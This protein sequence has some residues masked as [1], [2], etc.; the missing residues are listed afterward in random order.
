MN[1]LT[2]CGMGSGSSLILKMNVDEILEAEGR[3]AEVEACDIGSVGAHSADLIL[4]TRDFKDPLEEYSVDKIFLGNVVDKVAIK[5]ELD[6]YFEGK[7][8]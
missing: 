8:N 2:V 6:K 7:G 4:A 1:I 5:K 3:D